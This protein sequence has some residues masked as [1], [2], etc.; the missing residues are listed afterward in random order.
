MIRGAA[1]AIFCVFW[2]R[3]DDVCPKAAIGKSGTATEMSWT[4]G[5]GRVSPEKICTRQQLTSAN[6]GEP[7]AVAWPETGI[8][9]AR[10]KGTFT[11]SFCCAEGL[12]EKTE[13][14]RYGPDNKPLDTVLQ[15]AEEDDDDGEY[16][17]FSEEDAKSI[18]TSFTGELWNGSRYVKVDLALGAAASHPYRNQSVFQFTVMDQS[19]EPVTVEW[20]LPTE[21][22]KTRQGSYVPV[23]LEG[24]ARLATQVFNG[25]DQP[26]PARG[27]VDLKTADGKLLGRFT[28]R[29]FTK[30][31]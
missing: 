31:N 20:S 30:A 26:A 10:I 14:L 22:S 1:L 25:K 19:S 18:R 12:E 6:A 9:S 21:M 3:A 28:A 23:L 29:G 15:A 11:I 7:L 13:T 17:D 4:S 8:V 5:T 2:C 24:K 16:P 27:T